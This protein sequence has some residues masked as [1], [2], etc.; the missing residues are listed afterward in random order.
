MPANLSPEYKRALV[1]Q[2]VPPLPVDIGKQHALDQAGPIVKSGELHRLL[3]RGMHRLGGGQH[4]RRQDTLPHMPVQV[5]A[6][7][8]P[9][10]PQRLGVQIHGVAVGQEAEGFVL[11]SSQAVLT[12]FLEWGKTVA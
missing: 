9:E 7:H 10:P 8:Q 12:V 5:H 2:H 3:L 1:E 11:L 4:P 6:S